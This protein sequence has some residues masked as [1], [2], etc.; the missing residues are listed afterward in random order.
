MTI[1]WLK[2]LYI[3]I[4]SSMV[5]G[6]SLWYNRSPSTTIQLQDL[7]EG[8]QALVERCL[9]TQWTTNTQ[10]YYNPP[11][12]IPF[13]QY[14]EPITSGV[15]EAYGWYKSNTNSITNSATLVPYRKITYDVAGSNRNVG[16]DGEIDIASMIWIVP[17]PSFSSSI[18]T[19]DYQT[20]K[21]IVGTYSN[22]IVNG[23]VDQG[24]RSFSV[25]NGTYSYV[26]NINNNTLVYMQSTNDVHLRKITFSPTNTMYTETGYFP[27]FGTSQKQFVPWVTNPVVTELIPFYTNFVVVTTNNLDTNNIID[28]PCWTE[29]PYDGWTIINGI[30][31]WKHELG[32]IDNDLF[33]SI[34]ILNTTNSYWQNYYGFN[35][36]G[37]T[38]L[39]NIQIQPN[40]AAML[41]VKRGFWIET[42]QFNCA[43]Y[44]NRF[45]IA[46]NIPNLWSRLNITNI[47]LVAGGYLCAFDDNR[48][49]N[50]TIVQGSYILTKTML[51]QRQNVLYSLKSMISGGEM[52]G[53]F[54]WGNPI[55]VHW[56]SY[57]SNTLAWYG[58]GNTMNNA[59]AQAFLAGPDYS[60][61]SGQPGAYIR[62]H[63]ISDTSYEVFLWERGGNLINPCLSNTNQCKVAYYAH[64]LNQP[65]Y[66]NYSYA[67]NDIEQYDNFDTS[68]LTSNLFV[69]FDNDLIYQSRSNAISSVKIGTSDV[70]HYNPLTWIPPY[71]NDQYSTSG[72]I[73]DDQDVQADWQFL[74]CTNSIP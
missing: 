68:V 6:G 30:S 25:M 61:T 10:W 4:A 13:K 36:N 9:A 62:G 67:T 34:K 24:G 18:R 19:Y 33:G 39:H 41:G 56:Q 20:N 52:E 14:L 27:S 53:G 11:K 37:C 5:V 42:N 71:S 58:Y 8:R 60:T 45:D 64:T 49:T 74:Y 50:N 21:F 55:S 65:K 48:I 44:T 29:Q 70:F 26:T 66:R 32:V 22:L 72:Y 7:L 63:K 54:I 31:D 3:A 46:L 23:F 38:L 59:I 57:T 12:T 51:K 28:S 15:N 43:N 40:G 17:P 73:V 2:Y 47:Q 35:Q 69:R 16:L 1:K